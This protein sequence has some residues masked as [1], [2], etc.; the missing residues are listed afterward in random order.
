VDAWSETVSLA[1]ELQIGVREIVAL[2]E[3]RLIEFLSESV[4]EAVA[5]I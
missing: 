2:E 1:G 4:C 5:E 3:E